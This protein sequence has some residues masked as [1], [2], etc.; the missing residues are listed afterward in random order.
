[1]FG[2]LGFG[3]HIGGMMWD[4]F[5]ATHAQDREQETA[6]RE[7]NM[8]TDRIGQNRTGQDRKERE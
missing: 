1:M 7:Q 6:D 8:G 4:A 3:N 2:F 5:V